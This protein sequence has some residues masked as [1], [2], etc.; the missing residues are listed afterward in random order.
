MSAR[1]DL[2]AREKEVLLMRSALCRLRL[3]RRAGDARAALP[4]NRTA[5]AV[6]RAPTIRRM[7]FGLALSLA[8]AGR[9]ARLVRLA[10]RIVLAAKL[11][12][13]V[14]AYARGLARAPACGI[15]QTSP[16]VPQ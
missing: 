8:G 10:A 16:A 9:A 11:A 7:A 5:G 14:I 12:R 1:L 2:L 6:V 3:Q 4:W 13:P 15:E